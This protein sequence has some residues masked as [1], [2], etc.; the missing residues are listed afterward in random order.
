[1]TNITA[2]KERWEEG[3]AVDLAPWGYVWRRDR[4]VQ[5][6]PEAYLLPRR[7]RRQDEVYRTAKAALGENVRSI[8][9]RQEDLL[10]D[11]LPAPE[12]TLLTGLLWVGGITEYEIE[13]AW[14]AGCTPPSPEQ[15]DVRIYPTAWGWLGFSADRRLE[16]PDISEDGRRWCYHSPAGLMMDFAYS[17]RVPAA[18]EEVAV[19]APFDCPV[20]ELHVR[21]ESLGRWKSLTFS[22]EWGWNGQT[23]DETGPEPVWECETHLAV[24]REQ[25]TDPHARRVT[26]TVLYSPVSRYGNDSKLTV[27]LDRKT[28]KGAT[29]LLRELAE[30]PIC[31]PEVG[32]FFC[33][34][35]LS[36]SADEYRKAMQNAGGKSAREKVRSHGEVTD[37]ETLL[38]RV[39]L[40]R[41]P[42][43]TAVPDFPS[44]P[45]MP[46][47][48]RVPDQ[49]WQ[50]MLA[51]AADQLRGHNMWGVLALEVSRAT[52][53]ME[54]LGL[55]E[56]ADRIYDY[57]LP[58]PGIKADGDF[59]DPAGSL[60]WARAMRH[61][62]GY[63]HEGTHFSTGRLLHS[64]MHRYRFTGDR[65]WFAA[66]L[67]RLKQAANF[68]IRERTTY[69][70][71]APNRGSWHA[72]GLMPPAMMG[73]YAL[74]SCDWRWYYADNAFAQLGLRAFADALSLYGDPDAD[75]YRREA[76]A[77][78]ADLRSAAEREALWA[79]VRR[80]GDGMSYSFLP[81]MAYG[82]GLL[83]YGEETNIPQFAMGI[84]DLFQ[85]A[86]PMAEIGGVLRADDRRMEGTLTAMEEG[87]MRIST[88]ELEKLDHPTADEEGKRQAA[89][90]AADSA[91]AKRTA[92]A[93]SPDE[94]W[95]YN[96]FSN[97]PKISHNANIYLREDDVPN[98]LHFFFCHAIVMVGNNGKLWEHAHPDMFVECQDPDNGTVAWFV[99]NFRNMLMTE[100][101]GVLWL[102]KG[103][104]RAWLENG[105][106]ISVEKAPTFFG[107][108]SYRI[109]SETDSG[110]ITARIHTPS[111]QP[112]PAIR[113]RLRHPSGAKIREAYLSDGNAQDT[114]K[115]VTVD[116]D[117]E[118]VTI[119]D[120]KG[121][122]TLV[123]RY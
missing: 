66:R 51:L 70:K 50:T 55:R 45:T 81:R 101:D 120:P 7:I 91:A 9:Y 6:T 12:G 8:H 35:G 37:W 69:L 112:V 104:P 109:V 39:R 26:L 117:R 98:F 77:F 47:A 46:F 103:T 33:P 100:D 90:L 79:P 49:R 88:A 20:P 13:L 92:S 53:A 10:L 102:A 38:R 78:E 89:S 111:R 72:K 119:V 4:A 65:A 56:E 105:K 96:S 36:M 25:K 110:Q 28:G 42:D 99:E 73:D 67:P 1:M 85:G 68:I 82:G 5:S 108:L 40:W 23:C 57:F 118:T 86:L 58:S 21:G 52:L 60:E 24:I 115:S 114:A 76:D 22:V 16:H 62:M 27:I 31:V 34:E 59:S 84:S 29:V 14:P 3:D 64:M 17:T 107:E 123:A 74:P 32:L 113:L 43:G 15:V 116:E 18:T 83:H 80:A 11:P 63:N 94:L 97:L 48:V 95:F 121:T 44:A 71:E 93:P 122:L 87:G 54:M 41:C 30:K 2:D 61:D 75:L 106:E 19:F